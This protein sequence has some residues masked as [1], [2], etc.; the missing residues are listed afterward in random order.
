MACQNGTVSPG[1][2][3]LFVEQSMIS[4]LSVTLLPHLFGFV[5][6]QVCKTTRHHV[7]CLHFVIRT[8]LHVILLVPGWVSSCWI[9]THVSSHVS[10]VD[11]Q[12]N[13]DT[14]VLQ[15]YSASDLCNVIDKVSGCLL[16]AGCCNMNTAV[17]LIGALSG[18]LIVVQLH[19]NL[20]SYIYVP[21]YSKI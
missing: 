6:K 21:G 1:G 16:S 15:A 10:T 19:G 9:M 14:T 5:C 8:G 18:Y 2:M 7:F 12:S 13:R 17:G 11:A 3:E 4:L 20:S